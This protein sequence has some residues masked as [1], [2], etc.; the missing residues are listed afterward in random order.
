MEST[1][2]TGQFSMSAHCRMTAFDDEFC[3][4][5]EGIVVRPYLGATVWP[6]IVDDRGSC[7]CSEELR[8][9]QGRAP[10]SSHW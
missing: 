4:T 2:V 6:V 7:G 5:A 9:E 8:V 3:A 10:L 1:L